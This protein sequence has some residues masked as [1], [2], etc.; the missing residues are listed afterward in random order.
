MGLNGS[1]DAAEPALERLLHEFG[2]LRPELEKLI[3]G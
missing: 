2:R 1:P 3:A